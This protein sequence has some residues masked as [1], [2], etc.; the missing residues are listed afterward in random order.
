MEEYQKSSRSNRNQD[1]NRN[2]KSEQKSEK[3]LGFKK[4]NKTAKRLSFRE[5]ELAVNDEDLDI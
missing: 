5:V 4:R 3:A 2:R 1:L